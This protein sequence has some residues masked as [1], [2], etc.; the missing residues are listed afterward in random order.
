LREN[1]FPRKDQ[2]Q[3][4]VER[5]LISP[6]MRTMDGKKLHETGKMRSFTN[7]SLV[8][9]KKLNYLIFSPFP[10]AATEEKNDKIPSL[11]QLQ[12]EVFQ[13]FFFC[14]R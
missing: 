8:N 2:S 4:L 6:T 14:A 9:T 10:L 12:R 11:K 7:N 3:N 5:K 13:F 1:I